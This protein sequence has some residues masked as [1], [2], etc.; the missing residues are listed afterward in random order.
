MDGNVSVNADFVNCTYTLLPDGKVFPYKGGNFTVTVTAAGLKSCPAPVIY[1]NHDW[2]TTTVLNWTGTRGRV[3]LTTFGNPS[4]LTRSAAVL[5]GGALFAVQQDGTP[6]AVTKITPINK[7]FSGEGGTSSFTAI[8]S[9]P[10]C[11]W[12]IYN[13]FNW[14]HVNPEGGEGT[15]SIAYTVDANSIGLARGGY[16]DVILADTEPPKKKT[17]RIRQNP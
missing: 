9:A 10:D 2:L 16:I 5:I 3:K 15:A 14:I 1:E 17:F 11:A 6:C 12:A 4:S 7:F 8:I 13:P